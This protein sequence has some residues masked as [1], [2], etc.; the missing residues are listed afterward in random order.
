MLI[1]PSD[2]RR[3]SITP[4]LFGLLLSAMLAAVL[5]YSY[6][7]DIRLEDVLGNMAKKNEIISQMKTDLLRSVEAE[8]NAV[9]ADTDEDSRVFA[10]QALD[11]AAAVDRER[12]AEWASRRG[13]AGRARK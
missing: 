5:M 10:K 13:S 11:A 9:L 12:A 7:T 2:R 8:K 6:R 4:W 1:D 3:K